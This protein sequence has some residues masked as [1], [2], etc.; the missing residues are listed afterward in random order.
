MSTLSYKANNRCYLQIPTFYI[1]LQ[2]NSHLDIYP[3]NTGINFRFKLNKE[4]ILSGDWQVALCDIK[5]FKGNS[6]L[7]EVYVNCNIVNEMQV[8]DV[9]T[10]L[11]RRI[12]LDPSKQKWFHFEAQNK[13]YQPLNKF[14]ITEIGITITTDDTSF[15]PPSKTQPTTLLL[16][17]RK[18]PLMITDF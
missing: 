8:G 14:S 12:T 9:N 1:L 11:L 5:L 18:K 16:H 6:N 2:S 10:Q 15:R 4:L 13:Y 7:S 3:N 17:F